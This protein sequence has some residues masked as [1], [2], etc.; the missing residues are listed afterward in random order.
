MNP[1][2]LLLSST[3]SAPCSRIEIMNTLLIVVIGVSLLLILA[4]LVNVARRVYIL[5]RTV[6]KAQ[7]DV[8]RE[9]QVIAA[10]QERAL[11]ILESV[12]KNQTLIAE[13]S[14]MLSAGV[15]RLSYLSSE[16]SKAKYRLT[17]LQ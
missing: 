2:R 11:G 8:E 5:Y 12:Q 14:S 4:A 15:D 3:D 7:R 16:F 9:L 10:G 17:T 1:A 13:R 6:S